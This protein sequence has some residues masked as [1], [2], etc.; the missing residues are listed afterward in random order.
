LESNRVFDLIRENIPVD[1]INAIED[2]VKKS[3][4]AVY[5]YRN[6]VMGVLESIS[7]DYSNLELDAVN[8]QSKIADPNNM[9][10]LKDVLT[11]LG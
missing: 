11:K 2:G 6:S 10:L 3:A 7:T 8:L 9:A 4:D 5:T 1:E